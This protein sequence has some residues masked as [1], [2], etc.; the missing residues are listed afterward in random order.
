MDLFRKEVHKYVEERPRV[1]ETVSCIRHDMFDADE[2]SVGISFALRHRCAWQEAGRIKNDRADVYGFLYMLGNKLKVHF[3]AA[4]EERV[5]Y[6]GGTF[7]QGG[8]IRDAR[9][10]FNSLGK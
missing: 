9:D 2:E 3:S 8:D 10:F 4:P 5:I 6:H 1:W 7:R